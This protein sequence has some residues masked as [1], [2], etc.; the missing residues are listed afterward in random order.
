MCCLVD[1]LRLM[2]DLSEV[3]WVEYYNDKP[4]KDRPCIFTVNELLTSTDYKDKVTKELCYFTC[5]NIDPCVNK[6]YIFVRYDTYGD[7]F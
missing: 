6:S 2:P 5:I 7:D 1:L 4:V 3:T